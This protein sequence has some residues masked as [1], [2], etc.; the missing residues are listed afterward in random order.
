MALLDND[1]KMMLDYT[2]VRSLTK[3][4]LKVLSDSSIQFCR[5]ALSGCNCSFNRQ[6]LP[7]KIKGVTDLLGN[8]KKMKSRFQ[9]VRYLTKRHWHEVSLFANSVFVDS[10]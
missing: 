1:E 5:I 7:M 8:D 9:F 3:S 10:L 2:L 4:P 6:K